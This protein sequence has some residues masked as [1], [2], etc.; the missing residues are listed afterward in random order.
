MKNINTVKSDTKNRMIVTHPDKGVWV[1]VDDMIIGFAEISEK[2]ED[3]LVAEIIK[4]I[5]KDFKAHKKFA[6]ENQG[7][8]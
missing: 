3:P 2:C 7:L 6:L 4:S 1:N 5:S 8:L